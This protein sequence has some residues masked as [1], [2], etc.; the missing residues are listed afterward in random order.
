MVKRG[1][2]EPVRAGLERLNTGV[3]LKYIDL[4]TFSGR[5]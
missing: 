5:N 3:K 4:D 2:L 1:D